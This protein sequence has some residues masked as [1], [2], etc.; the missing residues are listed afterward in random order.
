MKIFKINYCGF[1]KRNWGLPFDYVITASCKI[2]D[3]IYEIGGTK[4]QRL[5]ADLGF[6]WRNLSDINKIE[7]YRKKKRYAKLAILYY[8]LVRTFGWI[9]WG[10]SN[11]KRNRG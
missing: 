6:L 2:H 10:I 3:D 7:D 11:I 4:D 9:S 1:G 5:Q 8:I